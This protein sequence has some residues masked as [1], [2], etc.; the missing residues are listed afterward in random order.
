MFALGV[1]LY[2]LQP[3]THCRR[4]ATSLTASHAA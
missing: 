1:T 3:W 4:L 2:D